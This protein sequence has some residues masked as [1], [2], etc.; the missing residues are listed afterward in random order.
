MAPL[1]QT[2]DVNLSLQGKYKLASKI[3]HRPKNKKLLLL[4]KPTKVN[5]KKLASI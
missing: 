2:L 4:V 3:L 5:F 1:F